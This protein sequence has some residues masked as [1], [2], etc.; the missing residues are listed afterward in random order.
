MTTETINQN[1]TDLYTQGSYLDKHPG[2]HAERS[3]WK[4]AHV[5]RGLRAANL[6]PSSICD[7]GCGTG[8][9]LAEVVKGLSGVERAVG[10][11]PSPDAPLHPAA[12]G[13]IEHRREDATESGEHFDLSIMLDVF[14]HVEDYFGFL[15][16]CRPLADHH[17]FHIPLDANARMV[18][19]SGCSRARQTLGHLHYFSRPTALATL[20]ET[21]YEPIHWH[22]TKSAW[23]GPGPGKNPWTPTNVLRRA[24]YVV[25]PEYTQR[26]L[27]GLSLLVVARAGEP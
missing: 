9:A 6:N 4:A 10:F 1:I 21:G 12:E 11:E 25:S 8:L 13:M 27:G 2:W 18:I 3:P 17:V 16:K 5:L 19:T 7:I 24:F 22:F 14:E 23:D 15:R 26:I 20:R